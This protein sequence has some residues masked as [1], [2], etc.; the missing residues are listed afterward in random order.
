[1]CIFTIRVHTCGHWRKSLKNPC[2]DAKEKKEVCDSGSEDSKTTGMLCYEDG[3]DKEPGGRRD[4]PG[5]AH[6]ICWLIY[7]K[8][9]KAGG[10]TDGGFDA[11][12]IDWDDF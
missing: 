10:I 8:C 1:M 9:D 12:D 3:C 2:D 4:G 5:K 11:D 7:A 6:S